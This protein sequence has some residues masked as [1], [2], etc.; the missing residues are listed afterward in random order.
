MRILQLTKKF[1][2]PPRDGES[3]AI[4]NLGQAL[5]AVG[6]E[7]TLLAMN[8]TRHYTEHPASLATGYQEV[9]TVTVDNKITL[10]GALKGILGSHSYHIS[11][12]DSPDFHA[13]LRKILQAAPFDIVQL[14]TLY[15][16]PYIST[17]RE[18]SAAKIVMRAHNVEHEI[19]ERMVAAN[20]KAPKM[21]LLNNLNS[22]LKNYE[23]EHLNAYDLLVPITARDEAHF[24]KLGFS[25]NSVVIPIG[26]QTKPVAIDWSA[27]EA[28]LSLSFIGSLD[29]MPNQEGIEW[30]WEKVWATVH[31]RHPHL[32]W[33]IAGRN[34]PKAL[35]KT[36]PKNVSLIGEVPDAEAFHFI[37]PVSLAPL[38]SG[39]GI[40]AK[41]LEAMALGRVVI[42]SSVALEGIGATHQHHVLIADTPEEWTTAIDWCVD[43]PDQLPMIGQRAAAF[44]ESEFSAEGLARKIAVAYQE[45]LDDPPEPEKRTD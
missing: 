6:H 39:S 40:R 11:R 42:A 21:R 28:P 2:F 43:H 8:T 15:L 16:A 9:K 18:N 41:I 33:V 24:R 29:W 34:A 1:P 27:Y 17:I 23:L 7:V 22:K 32:K 26:I 19:W 4:L 5:Q 45:L 3:L 12:F 10:T 38:L 44:I 35:H 31:E 14:E 30:I 25:G 13:T 20:P 36:A 37:H